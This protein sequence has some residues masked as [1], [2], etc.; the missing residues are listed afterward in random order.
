MWDD[1]RKNGVLCDFDLAALRDE[2]Q[3]HGERMGTVPYMAIDLLE[4]EY[5]EG[6][7]KRRYRHDVESFIW[8]LVRAAMPRDDDWAGGQ[9]WQTSDYE[10]CRDSKITFLFASFSRVVREK[11]K[12]ALWILVEALLSWLRAFYP[13]SPRDVADQTIFAEIMEIINKHWAW[14]PR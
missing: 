5:F 11:R 13:S 6:S 10:R 4:K 9:M 1:E 7:V 8:V 2:F 3:I 14:G 12:E